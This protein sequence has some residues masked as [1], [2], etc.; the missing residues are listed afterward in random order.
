MAAFSRF[1][2]QSIMK[3]RRLPD[4]KTLPA[5]LLYSMPDANRLIH[6][7]H[8]PFILIG[9]L[10]LT[11]CISTIGYR[12]I[13]TS[14]VPLLFSFRS[15]IVP[16]IKKLYFM[17]N[18]VKIGPYIKKENIRTKKYLNDYLCRH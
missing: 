2:R 17:R 3:Q 5:K 8:S 9:I 18:F 11:F 6:Y 7:I 15:I 12:D 16:F 4:G 13:S 10:Y 1:S 14:S